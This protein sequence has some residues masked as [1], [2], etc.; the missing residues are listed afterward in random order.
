MYDSHPYSTPGQQSSGPSQPE[1][2]RPAP[3]QSSWR[4]STVS[5]P[6]PPPPN[7]AVSAPSYNPNTY[8]SMT[9]PPGPSISPSVSPLSGFSQAVDTTSWGVRY[10]HQHPPPHHTPS[11]TPPPLPPRPSSTTGQSYSSAPPPT[12]SPIET[13]QSFSMPP[14]YGPPPPVPVT[15]QQWTSNASYASQ[16][17]FTSAPQ[18]PPPPP[19]PP[20]YAHA[21]SQPVTQLFQQPLPPAYPATVIDQ[22]VNDIAPQSVPG[23]PTVNLS[24]HP[25][26][27]EQPPT[28]TTPSTLPTT[29]PPVPPK[30]SPL[31]VAT[32]ASALGS[33]GPSDW[34]HLSP[35]PGDV[36]DVAA[37]EPRRDPA[38]SRTYS[39]LPTSTPV[40]PA[41]N[42]S[43][44]LPTTATPLPNVSPPTQH[45]YMQSNGAPSDQFKQSPVS[46]STS[47]GYQE[48]PPP[49]RVDTMES[50]YSTISGP[51]TSESI[52]KVIEA[53][54]RP[55]SPDKQPTL[56]QGTDHPDRETKPSTPV[57]GPSPLDISKQKENSPTE[58]MDGTSIDIT[59]NSDGVDNKDEKKVEYQ[60]KA[61]DPLEDLD[62]WSKS[63]LERYVAM[64]RK[65]AVA[66]SDEER[67]K[68]FTAFMAKETKLREILYNV[69][70][71]PKSD[72]PS[73]DRPTPV[74][75]SPQPE[76][77]EPEKIDSPIES[78]L[79]PVETEGYFGSTDVP[80]ETE[81]GSYS[82][83][84]RPI[85]PRL[86]T[87]IS[88]TSLQRSSSVAVGTKY[89]Q[90]L[91]GQ[92]QLSRPTSVPPTMSDAMRK[93]SLSPLT[94]NPPHAIYTPFRYA[95]GPQRGS[96][97]L[98]FDRP[99]YQA[100]SALR[101]ASAESG[102]MMSN[103]PVLA[104]TPTERPGSAAP[105]TTQ[106][107][108]DETFVGLIREKSV[109]Y[110]NRSSR[111][112]SS[113][114]PPLPAALRQGRPTGSIDELR[115]MVSSPL[116]KQSESAW[117]I[118]TKQD[119]EKYPNDF[120]YI[121]EAGTS[122]ESANKSRREQLDK[123]RMRRQEES[124][125][126]VDAL[127][128]EK[129]IGYADINVL[130]EEFRQTEARVQ[131]NEEREEV[132]DFVK[133]VFK[134]LETRLTEEISA[135]QDL[136]ESALS[137][138]NH[139]NSK[140]Q[141][142]ER[143]KYNLSHTMK[144]VNDIYRRL[145]LRYHKRLQIALDLERR[146]KK[147]ERRP[148]VFMGDSAEL[149]KVDADFD[150]MEKQNILRAA[151]DRDER[152][153]RLMDA[154]DEAIIH[155]LG[156]NQSL[157]DEILANV[158]KIDL[159]AIRSSGMADSEVEQMFKSVQYSVDSLRQDSESILRYFGLADAALN[160]AD[161][162]VSV[163]EARC[164]GA[165]ADVFRQLDE[166]K[167]KEDAKIQNDLKS[168]IASVRAGPAKI[169]AAMNDLLKCLGKAPIF[170]EPAPIEPLPA[171]QSVG[172]L[173]PGPRPPT[174][175]IT[176]KSSEEDP[177]HQERLRRALENAK[178]RNA[179]RVNPLP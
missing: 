166:E 164:S 108:N 88:A 56:G 21:V 116:A 27:S 36:D 110:R 138:L 168:K 144:L 179:A 38:H 171:G 66:D 104:P 136:Y 83:G 41:D 135:L 139:E 93:Q 122:W 58:Q 42:A 45:T 49:V 167:K 159:A 115:S 43:V 14:G 4:P 142:S 29:A 120:T 23:P 59:S 80:E 119:L 48:P 175:N 95:E 140:I 151:R 89:G 176:S 1:W 57:E 72:E 9:S 100:Y 61:P 94:T 34:E 90:G 123:E 44:S 82:P 134:P 173:L 11:P 78:G 127:F 152:A 20:G 170:E 141:D 121:R 15:H 12:I 137:Q 118:T 7:P 155:G 156:E 165:D 96:D 97:N 128:N 91:S 17:P 85:L 28:T 64:L 99:A 105:S 65:E 125:E 158:S 126:H 103:A 112:I 106:D 178:K 157:L 50:A 71:D 98:V 8:G 107:E 177:E 30:M 68:I 33:G 19:L 74:Q 46:P 114:P 174:A 47:L 101:Q 10:N 84:G 60:R 86:H 37:F 133:T 25:P 52:D 172:A 39:E 146:R 16:Q 117:H 67:Y 132:D 13:H 131:L 35:V 75:E 87:P 109:A 31:V 163:A 81:D 69:D 5:P 55:V 154:F 143:D 2:R 6:P 150:Q 70:H 148:L 53:W 149:K 153:N 63:S 129:E 111:R 124:E 76:A 22:P 40:A 73:T 162:Q 54:K 160:E 18:P 145:E 102:R 147:A 113:P 92:P 79:I 62:P 130:E 26:P 32:G 161:Y 24:P 51:G 169:L 77:K 3:T